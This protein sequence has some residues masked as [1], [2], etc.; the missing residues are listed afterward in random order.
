[1]NKSPFMIFLDV[2][3]YRILPPRASPGAAHIQHRNI[4]YTDSGTYTWFHSIFIS[5]G[6]ST[7]IHTYSIYIFA[8]YFPYM[9]PCVFLDLCSQQKTSPLF[10]GGFRPHLELL[11]HDGHVQSPTFDPISDISGPKLTFDVISR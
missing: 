11:R 8:E 9:L 3:T 5:W 2:P 10:S 6:Q 1:M 7:Q 4:Y